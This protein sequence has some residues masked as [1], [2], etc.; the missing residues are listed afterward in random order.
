MTAGE[1]NAFAQGKEVTTKEQM[2]VCYLTALWRTQDKDPYYGP[3]VGP[4]TSSE[5]G[6]RPHTFERTVDKMK[7]RLQGLD[8]VSEFTKAQAMYP[9]V[10]EYTDAFASM[11][12]SDV[13]SIAREAFTPENWS[14]GSKLR[15]LYE[16]ENREAY[17]KSKL[18]EKN[19]VENALLLYHTF[20]KIGKTHEEAV[21]KASK[22]M[23]EETGKSHLEVAR[24]LK[25]RLK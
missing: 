15:A 3:G 1:R 25:G 21:K 9:K 19:L 22:K 14:R 6:M 24:L 13:L 4:D 11:P 12:E 7:L 17:A 16:E 23:S 20:K 10:R 8:D 2:A 18:K 5:C